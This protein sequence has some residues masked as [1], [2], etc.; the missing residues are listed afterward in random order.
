MSKL[1]WSGL[2]VLLPMAAFGQNITDI[3]ADV[4]IDEVAMMRIVDQT[5]IPIKSLSFSIVSPTV[6]GDVPVVTGFHDAYIQFTSIASTAPDNFRSI[7]VE[8]Q[9]TLPPGLSLNFVSAP[10][11]IGNMGNF[12]TTSLSSINT[13][14]LIADGIES[15]FTGTGSNVGVKVLHFLDFNPELVRTQQSGMYLMRY[16]LS[17]Y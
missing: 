15:G 8:V 1:K 11:L 13:T 17:N 9:P 16:T 3:A 4:A 7:S 12:Y 14:G 2:A 5:G 10:S 6:A